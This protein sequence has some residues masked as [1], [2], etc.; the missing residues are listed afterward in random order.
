MWGPWQTMTRDDD[1]LSACDANPCLQCESGG[2]RARGC[3]QVSEMTQLVVVSDVKRACGSGLISAT[4]S[5]K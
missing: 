1:T 2:L 5:R 4:I 3:T